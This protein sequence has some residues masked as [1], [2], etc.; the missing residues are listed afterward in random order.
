MDKIATNDNDD[1]DKYMTKDVDWLEIS[2]DGTNEST[3]KVIW[4]K[5]SNF[6]AASYRISNY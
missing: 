1:W 6:Q 3:G 4:F 2:P 5:N